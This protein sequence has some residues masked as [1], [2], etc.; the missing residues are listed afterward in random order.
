MKF[1]SNWAITNICWHYV[2]AY[3]RFSV[4]KSSQRIHQRQY[5][6]GA[7]SRPRTAG[8]AGVDAGVMNS[9]SCDGG[10]MM[11]WRWA[12]WIGDPWTRP[13]STDYTDAAATPQYN[14]PPGA[15]WYSLIDYQLCLVASAC[16]RIACTRATCIF[17]GACW[18]PMVIES[19]LY[20]C[21]SHSALPTTIYLQFRRQLKT[22]LLLISH[23]F[24][25]NVFIPVLTA[26]CIVDLFLS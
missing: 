18:L 5:Q 10:G 11:K 2:S 22:H 4:T 21:L 24:L 26:K 7:I 20:F 25:I 17:T 12:A 14:Y 1:E 13:R 15:Y 19:I 23:D 8:S 6:S 9:I 16:S 3:R